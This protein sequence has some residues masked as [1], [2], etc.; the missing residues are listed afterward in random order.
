[1]PGRFG[2]NRDRVARMERLILGLAAGGLSTRE[3]AIEVDRS[4]SQ[5]NRVRTLARYREGAERAARVKRASGGLAP[6]QRRSVR[7]G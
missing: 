1:M 6:H 4:I 2:N 3:F 7:R 5:V